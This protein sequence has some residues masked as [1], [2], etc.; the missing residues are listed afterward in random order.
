[1]YFTV[2]KLTVN[3]VINFFQNL[4]SYKDDN[5]TRKAMRL[6]HK[7]CNANSMLLSMAKH[8]QVIHQ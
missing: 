6:L 5:M 4:A 1:M 2:F 3:F 7:Y 8:A